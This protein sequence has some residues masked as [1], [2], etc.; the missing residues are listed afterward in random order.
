MRVSHVWGAALL[1]A[2]SCVTAAGAT[3][4]SA[5]SS[6]QGQPFDGANLKDGSVSY[7]KLALA[8]GDIPAAKVAGVVSRSALDQLAADLSAGLTAADGRID[9]LDGDVS[10]VEQGL[11]DL[12]S[13][14]SSASTGA[15]L[16]HW[17]QLF[18]I[19]SGFDDG[20]DDV[21]GGA[22]AD[23][24]C[25]S[26]CVSDAEIAGV[27]ANKIQGYISPDQLAGGIGGQLIG[28]GSLTAADLAGEYDAQDREIQLG[29]V[30]GEKILDGTVAFRDLS[31][32][33]LQRISPI[34]ANSTAGDV[35]IP[36]GQRVQVALM[37][38]GIAPGDFLSVSPPMLADP[39]L[40]G[41]AR[42]TAA[43]E[44]TAWIFNPGSA[45]VVLTGYFQIFAI[46]ITH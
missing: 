27:S 16:V 28:D 7:S 11:D 32:Q 12:R 8:D 31:S 29:A 41:G 43:N 17:S 46:D 44:V 14:L 26:A 15:E 6:T 20:V 42:V 10:A 19:P 36:A 13:D 4:A 22:A 40:F 5:A 18:G 1:L 9:Q 35:S 23:L 24:I 38:P 37:A 39:L 21:D 2:A 45:D 3:A 33:V 30:T 34:V 25:A